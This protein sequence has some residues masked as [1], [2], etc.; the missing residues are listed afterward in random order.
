MANYGLAYPSIAKRDPATGNYS[1]GFH[2]GKA[3]NT[4]ITPNYNE[5]SLFGD[6]K[7]AEAVKEF[8]DADVNMSVTT[9]PIKAASTM[10]GHTVDEEKNAITYNAEDVANYVGYGFY[11]N[12]I[13]DNVK[14]YVAVVL[15][16]V[17]FAEAVENYTTKGDSME[18][19][20]PSISGKAYTDGTGNW[21]YRQVFEKES[22]AQAWIDE[23]LGITAAGS[24]GESTEGEETT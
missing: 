10:F 1:G 4:D 21:K 11:A 15:P 18:F 17:K 19:K 9:L 8:K 24:T 20:T 5:A 22:E 13:V 14:T 6:N 12:E 3:V 7:L 16:N 23:K 2:C